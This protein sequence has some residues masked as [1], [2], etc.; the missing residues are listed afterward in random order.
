MLTNVLFGL[1]QVL[2]RFLMIIIYTVLCYEQSEA[3]GLLRKSRDTTKDRL[4]DWRLTLQFY[5]FISLIEYRSS[6][7]ISSRYLQRNRIPFSTLRF[8]FNTISTGITEDEH[9]ARPAE[10]SSIY[11]V[12]LVVM[13]WFNLI[14]VRTHR[15]SIF[16][17]PPCCGKEK[18]TAMTP[19]RGA[20]LALRA[21]AAANTGHESCTH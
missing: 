13:Q 14:A 4:V 10:A 9:A 18:T 1:P 5:G 20:F 6:F 17:H 12:N 16:Q 19:C 8:D 15:L 11:F 21:E 2:S 7:V 3:D